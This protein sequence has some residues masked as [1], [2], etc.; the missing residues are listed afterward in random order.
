MEQ[1]AQLRATG[2]FRFDRWVQNQIHNSSL[3]IND[4]SGKPST[5]LTVD[6]YGN[7]T[8]NFKPLPPP[9]PQEYWTLIITVIV[10]SI[11]GWSWNSIVDLAKA[12]MQRKHLKECIEEIG[13]LDK[14]TIEEKITGYYVDGKISEDHRQ[15][16]KDKISEYYGSVK[17]SETGI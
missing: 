4:P 7:F 12:K 17:G 1:G 16:L 9:I 15:L 3:T 14:N 6:R 13:K 8:A 5:S 2:N 11:I 10:T